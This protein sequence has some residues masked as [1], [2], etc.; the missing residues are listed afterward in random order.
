MTFYDRY[1]SKVGSSSPSPKKIELSGKIFLP[2][3][4]TAHPSSEKENNSNMTT[5]QIVGEA[6][7]LLKKKEICEHF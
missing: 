1:V 5:S 6:L 3:S 7:F 4:N 2:V